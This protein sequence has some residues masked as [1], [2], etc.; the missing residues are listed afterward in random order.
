MLNALMVK[1][2]RSIAYLA[3]ALLCFV[4]AMLGAHDGAFVP[5]AILSLSCVAQFARPTLLGWSFA[6]A[7]VAVS[8]SIG[9]YLLVKDDYLI[10][11]GS[12][13]VVLVDLNYSIF[14][15]VLTASFVALGVWLLYVRPSNQVGV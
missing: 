14:F 12:R 7:L 3:C 10:S 13:P 15:I 5:G 4:I 8:A 11:S 1:G 9:V 2:Q 6:M